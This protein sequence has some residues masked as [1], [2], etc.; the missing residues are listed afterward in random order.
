MYRRTFHYLITT[1]CIADIKQRLKSVSS[2]N[3]PIKVSITDHR[4][5]TDNYVELRLR[6]V[7]KDL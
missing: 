4:T 3:S 1:E 6:N 2:A 7:D 5:N